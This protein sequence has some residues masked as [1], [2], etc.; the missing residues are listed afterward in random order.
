MIDLDVLHDVSLQSESENEPRWPVDQAGA[1]R[2]MQLIEPQLVPV[3]TPFGHR[4]ACHLAHRVHVVAHVAHMAGMAFVLHVVHVRGM[5]VGPVVLVTLMAWVRRMVVVAVAHGVVR[6]AL[7]VGYWRR[8]AAVVRA[9]AVIITVP[10]VL[11]LRTIARVARRSLLLIV[12]VGLSWSDR[13]VGQ[14]PP[15][16]LERMGGMTGLFDH[17]SHGRLRHRSLDAVQPLR[18]PRLRGAADDQQVGVGR[19]ARHRPPPPTYLCLHL[20]PDVRR[21]R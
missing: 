17:G 9:V 12:S 10:A 11:P 14:I 16:H 3:V 4:Q 19:G 6:M 18:V 13:S 5:V 2:Y 8:R 7:I 21:S 15:R 20:Q 1:D